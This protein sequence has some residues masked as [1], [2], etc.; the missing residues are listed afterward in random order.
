MAPR[1]GRSTRSSEAPNPLAIGVLAL[2][3]LAG[4]LMLISLFSTIAS[5]DVANGSCEVIN[6]ANPE[7]ADRCSLSGFER[8]S[9]AFLLLG[10][11]CLALAYGA[12]PGR[13]RPAAIGLLAVG[14]VAL[15]FALL[16]DLPVTDDTGAIGRDFEGATA[17]AGTGLWIEVVSGVLALAAGGLAL[18]IPPP[19]PAPR[20]RRERGADAPPPTPEKTVRRQQKRDETQ[21]PRADSE[22]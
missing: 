8:H 20:R 7:L 3:V 12:G 22:D 6:D 4:I 18:L 9:I 16:V 2:G 15:I 17:G 14:A 21:P 13:S 19:A 10:V 1:T 11:I 5:V